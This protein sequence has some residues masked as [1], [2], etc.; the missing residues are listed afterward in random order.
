LSSERLRS[1]VCC[2]LWGPVDPERLSCTRP[3]GRAGCGEHGRAS[4]APAAAPASGAGSRPAWG[5][6][7]PRGAA[8]S[9][10]HDCPRGSLR[11]HH[12]LHQRGPAWDLPEAARATA[13]R[14]HLLRGRGGAHYGQ[15]VPGPHRLLRVPGQP[16]YHHA[17]PAAV[18]H[19]HLHLPGH[20]GGQCLRLR[21]PGPGD[22]GTVPRMAQM[23][24]RP[25]KGL[26][27]PCPTDRLR[28]P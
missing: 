5:P 16:D 13:P 17:P 1:P 4:E 22:R 7:C 10:L 11:Q 2:S 24:G 12:L 27:P 14:H 19:W 21:H 25:T 15:T 23:L 8:V 28:P 3:A 26:C 9:P 6:G 20:H 18:G